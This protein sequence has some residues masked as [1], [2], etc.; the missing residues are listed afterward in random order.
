MKKYKLNAKA[1]VK[2]IVFS[3]IITFILILIVTCIC[4][5][6]N[7]SEKV[8]GVM[9]FGISALSVFISSVL[10]GKGVKE[11]GLIYGILN[12][13][14]YFIVILIAAVCFSGK[15]SPSAQSISM[16]MGT[17]FSG[18]LGGIVGVNK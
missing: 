9:L 3:I 18:A 4:Y 16:L 5:W 8:L 15:F 11:K 14:G 7:V 1:L 6:G 17:A 2:G 12:G 10:L 13:L